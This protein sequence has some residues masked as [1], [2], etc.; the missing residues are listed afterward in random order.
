MALGKTLAAAQSALDALGVEALE[1]EQQ[2]DAAIEQVTARDVTI[3][4]LR[5]AL[6][7]CEDTAPPDPVPDPI[8]VGTLVNADDMTRPNAE[9]LRSSHDGGFWASGPARDGQRDR[10]APGRWNTAPPR[11]ADGFICLPVS[12]GTRSAK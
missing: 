3:A 9:V 10:M 11:S 1:V 12:A 2:R 5:Q 4:E 7:D 8:P 6:A